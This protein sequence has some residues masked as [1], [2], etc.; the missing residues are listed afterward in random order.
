MSILSI[1][2][3]FV[4]RISR[5]CSFCEATKKREHFRDVVLAISQNNSFDAFSLK[6]SCCLCNVEKIS[7]ERTRTSLDGMVSMCSFDV[8]SLWLLD[9]VL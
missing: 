6:L 2:F 4:E 5:S 7:L 1:A 9:G 3:P 8:A